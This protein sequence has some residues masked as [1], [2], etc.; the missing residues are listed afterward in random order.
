[1]KNYAYFQ[2]RFFLFRRET[3]QS[4][5]F[6][7]NELQELWKCSQ[8]QTKR[9]LKRYVEE[10]RITYEPGNGRGNSSKITF[11]NSFQEEVESQVLQLVKTNKLEEIIMLLQLQ[12]PPLW[13]S[14]VSKEVQSLFGIHTS[15]QSTDI[16]RTIITR[17]LTTL[18]P[19]YTAINF[20]TYLINQL[21]DSLLVYNSKEDKLYPHIAHNWE[22]D[23]TGKVWTF[24]LRKGI[25]F[26]NGDVLTS[27][28][29]KYTFRRF[30]THYT[31]HYWLVEDIEFIE[32]ITPFTIR[33]TLRRANL[34]FP[35][36]VASY[37]LAILPHTENFNENIWIGSGAFQLKKRSENVLILKAFENYFLPRPLLDEIQIYHMPT[38]ATTSITYDIDRD[39]YNATPLQSQGV[40]VGF[41]FLAFNFKRNT[42]VHNPLFRRA[43]FEL[44]D[45]P[46]MWKDLNRS[47][48][49][50]ATS[51]F[52][53][54]STP[55]KKNPTK[56]SDL[57]NQAGYKGE[58]LTVYTLD[59]QSYIEEGEWL[60]KIAKEY[61]L[62]LT[63]KTYTLNEYYHTILEEADL[64][65]MGEVASV[66]YHLSFMGAFL[67]KSLIFSRF[68]TD[69]YMEKLTYY[70]DKIKQNTNW[71][72]REMWIEKAENYIKKENLFIYLYHP[73]KTRSFHPM[74]KDI[75]FESF[76]YVDLKRLW[77]K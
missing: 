24:Y 60:K 36:Y 31:P 63:I 51:Y 72:T 55:T 41:Q 7:L 57:L 46:L 1:M 75:Q 2:M 49:Q 11:T 77:I 65:F 59:K 18:D 43:I 3:Y 52:H 23:D 20:E 74:I 22:R 9:R 67:N 6:K 12:I 33:F 71:K 56:I 25:R 8:K 66:D 45:L 10:G 30:L 70:L 4:S 53:W 42:I 54:K 17:K 62:K 50:E 34:F 21:G 29:V 27:E 15:E 73:I 35:R 14:N 37:N 76:G 40:E 48:L 64:L 69:P 44:V 47:N 39:V 19:L 26:H 5:Q 38:D 68:L 32:C 61:G 16:L 28:D 58:T 13:I